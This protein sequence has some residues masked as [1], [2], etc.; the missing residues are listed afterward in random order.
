MFAFLAAAVF[1]LS[2]CSDGGGKA[3]DAGTDTDADTDTDSDADGGSD[4]G[5]DT[6]PFFGIVSPEEGFGVLGSVNA[7]VEVNAMELDEV[8]FYLDESADAGCVDE[9]SYFSCF[10]D[11]SAEE[12]GSIHE[13]TAVGL[14]GG[15]EVASD[16]ITV[17][18]IAAQSDICT[19]TDSGDEVLVTCLADLLGDELVVGNVGDSYDNRD[20]DH[21]SL[22]T[23]NHPDVTYL[24]LGYGYEGFGT[25]P[26]NGDPLAPLIGNASLCVTADAGWCESMVRFMLRYG[27]PDTFYDLYTGSNFYWFPEHTDHDAEDLAYYMVPFTNCSQGSSG[28]EMDEV[29]KWLYA[30]AALRPETKTALEESGLLMPALQMAFRRT[31]VATDSEYMSS[32]AHANAFDDVDNAHEMVRMCNLMQPDRLPPMVQLEVIEETWAAGEQEFTTPVAVAR[33]WEGDEG[34]PRV[35]TV[36]AAGSFDAADLPLSYHW[37]IVRGDPELIRLTPL[38]ELGTEMEIEFQWHA[39]ETIDIGGTDRI[40]TLAV[41]GAFVHNDVYFSAPAFVTSST[42][43][44]L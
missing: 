18:R 26:E 1:S 10:F 2:A 9:P 5:A 21:T 31:R 7:V 38:D 24:H 27:E 19:D 25:A 41:V 43:D 32:S 37:V 6:D 28:S 36:S 33:H 22:N 8:R 34:T 16:S 14:Q 3:G 29:E 44:D 12:V 17:E 20:G 13:I 15:D 40:S 23:A 4:G 39:A 42:S 11:L 35:M 30:L